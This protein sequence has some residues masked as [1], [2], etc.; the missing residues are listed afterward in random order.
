M[1]TVPFADHA[2][3]IQAVL[4][5]VARGHR[6]TPDAADEFSSWAYLKLLDDD[7]AILRKFKGQ[8]SL[9]TYLVTVIQRL[10]LDWRVHE[11]GKWRPSA[12]ARRL[13]PVA[14]ELERLVLRDDVEFGQAVSVLRG[15]GVAHSE[16]EC[17]Q[18]WTRLPK[19]PPRRRASETVLHSL[20]AAA[21]DPLPDDRRAR[22]DHASAVLKATL[23]R[24]APQEQL[25]IR[26]HFLDGIPLSRVATL[27]GEDSKRVYTRMERLLAQ[28]RVSLFA[29]GVTAGEIRDLLGNGV[30]EIA[31]VLQQV[32]PENAG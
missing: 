25:M 11:W 9:R 21:A 13:G 2:D 14:V 12:E 20:A 7:R 5:Y 32:A 17:E 8:S 16:E 1:P 27:V 10:Y 15:N 6:L 19:V 28:M 18:V 26:L 29:G 3:L 22:A 23:E 30:V 4:A 24:L 31:P